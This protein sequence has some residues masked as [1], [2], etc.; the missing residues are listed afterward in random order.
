MDWRLRNDGKRLIA[1]PIGRVDEDSWK[2]FGAQLS[3]AV[4]EAIRA[5]LPLALD[6]SRLEYMTSKGLRALTVAKNEA[7]GAV[8]IHLAAPNETMRRILSISRYDM[9]F[10]VVDDVDLVR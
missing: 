4:A 3:G 1:S 2:D 8:T 10:P 5:G 9:L 6:L 7:K